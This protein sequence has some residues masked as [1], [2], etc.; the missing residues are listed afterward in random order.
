MLLAAALAL[1][2]V[3]DVSAAPA[4][5]GV[6]KAIRKVDFRNFAYGGIEEGR[7]IKVVNGEYSQDDENGLLFVN[8]GDVDHG[9]I[10]G[11]GVEEAVVTLGFSTGGSG[12]FTDARVFAMRAGKPVQVASLGEGD[13]ADGGIDDV[14]II[15]GVLRVERFGNDGT[16][17][18]CPSLL[19]RGTWKLRTTGGKA[20]LV[21]TAKPYVRR[22]VRLGLGP[23][24][25]GGPTG[26]LFLKGTSEAVIEGYG[27][28][29][30]WFV[31]VKGDRASIA[32]ASS[33]GGGVSSKGAVVKISGPSTASTLKPGQKWSGV[34]SDSGRFMIQIPATGAD[35]E[36]TVRMTLAIR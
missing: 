13:R 25:E 18:C 9:D 36:P 7:L 16:G 15:N 24:L 1:A 35:T 32:A 30:G 11:D 17:S 10:D 19:E 5:T 14:V 34:V 33:I 21:A 6:A 23:E 8:V 4:K 22:F 28:T 26:I 20:V 31:A 2:G 3:V 12:F 29:S 27:G